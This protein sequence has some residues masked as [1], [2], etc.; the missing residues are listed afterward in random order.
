[1]FINLDGYQRTLQDERTPRSPK[2]VTV[3]CLKHAD[4]RHHYSSAAYLS[5]TRLKLVAYFHLTTAVPPL[6]N[7]GISPNTKLLSS[8]SLFG[9]V[10]E[11]THE[12][13][14]S[15]VEARETKS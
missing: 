15:D 14:L 9:K 12:R 10:V 11:I 7:S 3:D 5:S 8:W 1:M 13:P 4:V 6:L 2:K